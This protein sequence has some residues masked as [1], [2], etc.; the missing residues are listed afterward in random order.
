[1]ERP[2]VRLVMEGQPAPDGS[3]HTPQ[4]ACKLSRFS[5][6]NF[7][8]VGSM[9]VATVATVDAGIEISRPDMMSIMH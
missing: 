7:H 1:M 3:G 8:A 4:L 5:E 9:T 2:E 6:T